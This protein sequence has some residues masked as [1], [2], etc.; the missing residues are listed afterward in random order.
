VGALLSCSV[1]ACDK[2]GP[3]GAA[4]AGPDAGDRGMDGIEKRA[5]GRTA[6]ESAQTA[7]AARD[8][9]T[10]RMVRTY[11]LKRADEP[12]LPADDIT[13]IELGIQCLE[14]GRSAEK[15][16]RGVLARIPDGKLAR[17]TRAACLGE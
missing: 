11:V 4:G 17:A 2:P 14:L 12:L 9:R 16:A 5:A 7:L 10:L 8:I 3:K 1:L 6:S 13:L 15:S